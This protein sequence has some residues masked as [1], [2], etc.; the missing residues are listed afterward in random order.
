MGVRVVHI[1]ECAKLL[2]GEGRARGGRR[3]VRGATSHGHRQRM[4]SPLPPLEV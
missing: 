2:K 3:G 4:G 1:G